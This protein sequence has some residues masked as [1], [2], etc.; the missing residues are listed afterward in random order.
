MRYIVSSIVVAALAGSVAAAEIAGVKLDDKVTVAGKELVLNGAGLR[1]RAV[2]KVYVSG[3]YLPAKATTTAAVLAAVPRRVTLHML[4]NLSPDQLVDA[5]VD[6]LKDNTGASEFAV[7]KPQVDQMTGILK[8]FGD[9]KEAQVMTI[10]YADN[11]TRLTLNGQP[12][13]EI[14][15][16]PFNQ[17]LMRVWVGDKPAQ[18][19]LKRAMLNQ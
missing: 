1:T 8:S 15:G 4:R 11:V 3:L 10:D 16:E 12:K 13:G 14:A 5:L 2:F 9:V 7:L 6:G 17:A 18:A 19:D